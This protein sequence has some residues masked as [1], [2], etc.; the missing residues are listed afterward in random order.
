M[1][2][3][4]TFVKKCR[5]VFISFDNEGAW[6]NDEDVMGVQ[7]RMI[8]HIWSEVSANDQGLID[9]VNEY[10]ASQDQEPVNV[11]VPSIPFPRI[12][13]CEAIE[14][15]KAGGGEIEWGDDIESHHCC[16]L[17]T[18]PSPRDLSTSRMPSSA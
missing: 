7:E 9:V 2:E 1:N 10:R 14:I 4:G 18:S 11:E 15:V 16:L 3:F 17:Y 8:H 13:Y 5:I 12:P 6:M